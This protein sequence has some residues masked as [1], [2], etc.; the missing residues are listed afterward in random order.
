MTKWEV[1]D[2]TLRNLYTNLLSI[3]SSFHL[4]LTSTIARLHDPLRAVGYLQKS[5]FCSVE[6]LFIHPNIRFNKSSL[7]STLYV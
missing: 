3:Q 4:A 5:V 1:H 6:Q 7:K 2:L